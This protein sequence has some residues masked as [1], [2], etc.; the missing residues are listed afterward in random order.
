MVMDHDPFYTLLLIW[1]FG[2]LDM[3]PEARRS[4]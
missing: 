4:L 2:V 1:M 3:S